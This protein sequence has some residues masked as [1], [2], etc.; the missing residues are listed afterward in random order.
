MHGMVAREHA[1]APHH[2]CPPGSAGRSRGLSSAELILQHSRALSV[3]STSFDG[4]STRAHF[5]VDELERVLRLGTDAVSR[6]RSHGGSTVEEFAFV[7]IVAGVDRR[8]RSAATQWHR[9][10]Q[11][12]EL[13]HANDAR[14]EAVVLLCP[15]LRC[16]HLGSTHTCCAITGAA[17]QAV[18]EAAALDLTGSQS[19]MDSTGHCC[20]LQK[21]V[22]DGCLISG[23]AL[24]SVAQRCPQLQ[25]FP[26]DSYLDGD[27]IAAC[28]E[29]VAQRCSQLQV[30][31]LSGAMIMAEAV[32]AIVHH[33]PVLKN[34]SLQ[35]CHNITNI[36]QAVAQVC[37]QLQQLDFQKLEFITDATVQN[38]LQ[39][40]PRLQRLGV[41]HCRN[42]SDATVEALAQH[43]PQL[44]E[45]EL[46][47]CPRITDA[48]VIG[49]AQRCPQLHIR[50]SHL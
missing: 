32:R 34:L 48:A 42:I 27:R 45:L 16:L 2:T 6:E 28:L 40:C 46:T 11:V 5:P 43:C 30:L 49:I 15:H 36:V 1:P 39:Q 19:V 23:P 14:V 12:M 9:S 10:V 31:T 44:R 8:W 21:L 22:L 7:G 35:K 37:P 17:V 20:Q 33:C 26:L 47:G 50:N 29:A 13:P 3:S 41:S 24:E 4:S 18:A 38:F 25:Q